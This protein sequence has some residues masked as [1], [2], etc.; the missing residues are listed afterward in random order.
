MILWV[1]KL[2]WCGLEKNWMWHIQSYSSLHNIPGMVD[3]SNTRI[4]APPFVRPILKPFHQACNGHNVNSA[5][6]LDDSAANLVAATTKTGH[7]ASVCRDKMDGE[8]LD[9]WHKLKLAITNHW[10]KQ[11]GQE[12]L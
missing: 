8:D 2:H 5:D 7:L 6:N 9:G 12:G 11:S 4:P 10:Q 3:L 1:S